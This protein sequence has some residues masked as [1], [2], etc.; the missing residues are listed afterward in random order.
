M[1]QTNKQVIQCSEKRHA[2]TMGFYESSQFWLHSHEALSLIERDRQIHSDI[3]SREQ[4][5]ALLNHEP[6]LYAVYQHL[7]RLGFIVWVPSQYH[8][9]K[10]P[11]TVLSWWEKCLR[12]CVQ[13]ARRLCQ[14]IQ[15]SPIIQEKQPNLLVFK[16]NT[17]F[18]RTNPGHPDFTVHVQ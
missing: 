3:L 14:Y 13:M 1:L 9:S 15:K 6:D 2:K 8:P 11:T 7:I 18:K 4:A 5:Y 16:P 10:A 17:Q 12:W